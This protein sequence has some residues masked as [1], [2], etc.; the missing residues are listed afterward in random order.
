WIPDWRATHE[1][2]TDTW[3]VGAAWKLMSDK[4]EVSADLAYS[5]YEGKIEFVLPRRY[6][7]LDSDLT[8]IRLSAK[9]ALKDNLKLGV[10]YRYEDYTESD[11]SKGR[12]GVFTLP[13]VLGL[14]DDE[15]EY[16][17]SLFAA[18]LR[19]AF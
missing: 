19:Y 18:Y 3:G 13:T 11:W 16:G 5:M 14:S 15:Q 1:N 17:G 4:L 12:L 6:P 8:S 2:V 10:D 9:Y 7:D